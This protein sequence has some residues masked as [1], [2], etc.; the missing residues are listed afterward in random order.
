MPAGKIKRRKKNGKKKE[1]KKGKW[2][3]KKKEKK[4]GKEKE[5]KSTGSLSPTV[6]LELGPDNPSPQKS[7]TVICSDVSCGMHRAESCAECPGKDGTETSCNGQCEWINNACVQSINYMT[8]LDKIYNN[9][10]FHFLR[11]HPPKTYH[12]RRCGSGASQLL[13][14]SLQLSGRKV[15]QV[16]RRFGAEGDKA[17]LQAG[18]D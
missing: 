13:S 7:Y 9:T 8:R 3:E 4:K 11:A 16:A 17:Q 12:G 14:A 15:E 10:I 5:K 18:Q 6:N 2:K 1:K